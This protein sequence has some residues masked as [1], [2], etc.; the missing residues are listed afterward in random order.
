MNTNPIHLI[1]LAGLLQLVLVVAGCI[2]PFVFDWNRDLAGARALTRQIFWTY[3]GYILAANVFFAVLCLG[4][5][6]ALLDGSYL[7]RCLTVYLCLYWLVRILLQFTYFDRASAP[8]GPLIP[9][10]EITLVTTF[11]LLTIIYGW[12]AAINWGWIR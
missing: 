11:I 9:L 8:Q 7:A 4:Q 1:V 6:A 3:A 5:P 10:A 12:A 2:V